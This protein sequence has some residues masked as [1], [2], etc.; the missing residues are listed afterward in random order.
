MVIFL[1]S[2]LGLYAIPYYIILVVQIRFRCFTKDVNTFCQKWRSNISSFQGIWWLYLLSYKRIQLF[3]AG[4]QTKT[5]GSYGS[6]SVVLVSKLDAAFIV[7]I[8]QYNHNIFDITGNILIGLYDVTWS[9]GLPDFRTFTIWT[10]FQSLKYPILI[11]GF[12]IFV[13]TVN[14]L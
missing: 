2:D 3:H 5:N 9:I 10:I 8:L 6:Q 11:I 13:R 14:A 7:T 4:L 12:N 1:V